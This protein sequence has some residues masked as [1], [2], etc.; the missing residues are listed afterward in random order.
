M[1]FSGDMQTGFDHLAEATETADNLVITDPSG[2]TA[3]VTGI[4]NQDV[5][6]NDPFAETTFYI[7]SNAL[8]GSG[9]DSETP[10][11]GWVLTWNGDPWSV[12]KVRDT[13]DGTYEVRTR[14]P[15]D[16]V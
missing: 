13:A 11:N 10:Q 15:E 4:V 8:S 1:S 9:L 5:G 12:Q 3:T 7:K 2:N 6:A 14:S 16:G